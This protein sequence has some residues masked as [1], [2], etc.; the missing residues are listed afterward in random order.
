MRF[1]QKKK[2][3]FEFKI[4]Q[5]SMPQSQNFSQKKMLCY[6]VNS[7]YKLKQ[8]LDVSFSFF[9]K[10]E[11]SKIYYNFP[12]DKPKKP[13]KIF[14]CCG[15][16]WFYT[17]NPKIFCLRYPEM[18]AGEVGRE[19]CVWRGGSWG[20]GGG[21]VER[22]AQQRKIFLFLILWISELGN[23]ESV[24]T[25]IWWQNWK[26]PS[27]PHVLCKTNYKCFPFQTKKN[28]FLIITKLKFSMIF[29]NN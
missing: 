21:R 25:L 28:F 19:V 12:F 5:C 9:L 17:F 22:V 13:K 26:C 1:Y 20:G 8:F 6:D 11:S 3:L 10:R 16:G 23:T 27:F 4:G 14:A 7:Q 18:F 15:Q 29:T 2:Q 24:P